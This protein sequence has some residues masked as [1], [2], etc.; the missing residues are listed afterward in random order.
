MYVGSDVAQCKSSNDVAISLG[1][2]SH[3]AVSLFVALFALTLLPHHSV[4]A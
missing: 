3:S 2:S 1:L 4:S